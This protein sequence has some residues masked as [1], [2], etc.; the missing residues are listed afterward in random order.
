M[1]HDSCRCV[2]LPILCQPQTLYRI[3]V[4]LQEH[5]VFEQERLLYMVAHADDGGIV[6]ALVAV[7]EAIA[8]HLQSAVLH[9]LCLWLGCLFGVEYKLLRHLLLELDFEVGGTLGIRLAT[10][11]FVLLDEVLFKD[12]HQLWHAVTL[13]RGAQRYKTC[14]LR[15][16]ALI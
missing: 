13:L 8:Q 11:A 5:L 14:R 4:V 12:F 1:F 2:N 6:L 16:H 9:S 10:C 3:V 15:E 7:F